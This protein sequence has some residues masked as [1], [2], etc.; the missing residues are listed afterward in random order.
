MLPKN[1]TKKKKR[2]FFYKKKYKNFKFK[3]KIKLLKTYKK[4]KFIYVKDRFKLKKNFKF[5]K[6]ITFFKKVIKYNKNL[7]IL[8]FNIFKKFINSFNNLIYNL[9]FVQKFSYNKFFKKRKIFYNKKNIGYFSVFITRNNIRG[10]LSNKKYELKYWCT[11]ASLK[12]IKKKK[13]KKFNIDCIIDDLILKLKFL[14]FNK[15]HFKFYAKRLFI[16]KFLNQIKK[17]SYKIKILSLEKKL[18]IVFNGC[19]LSKKKRKKKRLKFS[20]PFK[21]RT[22]FY[23]KNY[24]LN[25]YRVI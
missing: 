5:N 20:F 24:E 8:K 10:I 11:P 19:K 4:R 14:R 9:K 22:L 6:R 12:L 23:K 13:T 15:I 2:I 21:F 17:K 25:K 16:K 3:L 18:N 7:K 1:F